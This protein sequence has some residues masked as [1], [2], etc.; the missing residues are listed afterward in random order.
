MLPSTKILKIAELDNDFAI[1]CATVEDYIAL[2]VETYPE[3]VL[4]KMWTRFGTETCIYVLDQTEEE[5]LPL[6]RILQTRAY[7][8]ALGLD[9]CKP[10]FIERFAEARLAK[11]SR[12]DR[13]IIN[14]IVTDTHLDGRLAIVTGL[15]AVWHSSEWHYKVTPTGDTKEYM[16]SEGQLS[17]NQGHPANKPESEFI[18]QDAGTVRKPAGAKKPVKTSKELL[19]GMEDEGEE[20][21]FI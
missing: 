4:R 20:M 3:D 7:M 1:H 19:D 5:G 16:L 21:P 9:I 15:K 13:V 2:M 11:F 18:N 6:T 14:A 8:E 12:S 17:L 10:I